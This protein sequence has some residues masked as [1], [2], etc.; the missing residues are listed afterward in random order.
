MEI[1]VAQEVMVDPVIA[2]D[3][4]SYERAAIEE[5]IARGSSC[6]PMTG[7]LLPHCRLLPNFAL[8]SAASILKQLQTGPARLH[9]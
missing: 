3:G 4:F 5:W 8:R 7:A 1:I 9:P 2:G 6:S